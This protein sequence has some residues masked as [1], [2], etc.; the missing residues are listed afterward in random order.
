MQGIIFMYQEGHSQKR[1]SNKLPG[2]L[3]GLLIGPNLRK[4]LPTYLPTYTSER[5]GSSDISNRCDTSD[6]TESNK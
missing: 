6:I 1:S 3:V 5:S 4:S 2:L